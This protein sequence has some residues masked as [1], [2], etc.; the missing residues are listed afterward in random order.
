MCSY[1]YTK[2]LG[3]GK[4]SSLGLILKYSHYLNANETENNLQLQSTNG[5]YLREGLTLKM[6]G[7]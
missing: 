6:E 3:P 1:Y 2:A 7:I 4:Y 5:K